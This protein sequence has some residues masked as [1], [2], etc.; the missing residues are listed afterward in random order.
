MSSCSPCHLFY[1]LYSSRARHVID[2]RLCCFLITSRWDVHPTWWGTLTCSFFNYVFH[3]LA[4]SRMVG[5][6]TVSLFSWTPWPRLTTAGIGGQMRVRWGWQRFKGACCRACWPPAYPC[7][8]CGLPPKVGGWT[9]TDKIFSSA[10]PTLHVRWL[11]DAIITVNTG[12]FGPRHKEDLTLLVSWNDDL[13]GST[14]L[15]LKF[16]T[17][18]ISRADR[19]PS[20]TPTPGFT[21]TNPLDQ[22][23]H[24]ISYS[25]SV[26]REIKCIYI[27]YIIYIYILQSSVPYAQQDAPV[28][29][30][31]SM[32]LGYEKCGPH[33]SLFCAMAYKP[34]L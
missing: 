26:L 11:S 15:A 14:E 16:L 19:I 6:V 30:P 5:R 27:Y 13:N 7:W 21:V 29:M 8:A 3:L 1:C 10:E 25:H 34:Y 23:Q 20:P 31:K 22:G 2:M 12:I 17:K 4:M 18:K 24:A 9:A 28:R 33:Y 32:F